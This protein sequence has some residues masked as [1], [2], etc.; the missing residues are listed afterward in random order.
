[1]VSRA[2]TFIDDLGSASVRGVVES[3]MAARTYRS[4][5]LWAIPA[6]AGGSGD[7]RALMYTGSSSLVITSFRGIN[8]N[9]PAINHTNSDVSV[10]YSPN[11]NL[12]SPTTITSLEGISGGAAWAANTAKDFT[13]VASG[14]DATTAV[15]I[16]VPFVVPAHH[17]I[18]LHFVNGETGAT[19]FRDISLMLTAYYTD[20]RIALSPQVDPA[21]FHTT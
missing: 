7:A 14:V 18:S 19:D 3:L 12:S 9:G 8:P 4:A 16:V 5:E 6:A 17:Y 13:S 11:S 15:P 1:V 10:I 2:R 21:V 20:D